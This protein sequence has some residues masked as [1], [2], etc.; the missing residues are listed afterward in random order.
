MF[1]EILYTRCRRGIDIL[2]NQPLTTDGF[3]VYACS[4]ALLEKGV[5]DLH[6]VQSVM[7]RKQSYADPSFMD[8]AYLYYVPDTGDPLLVNFHPVRFDAAGGGD[9]AKRPGNFLN[10]AMTGDFSGIYPYEMFGDSGV[11][12]AERQDES[13]FYETDPALFRLGLPDNYALEGAITDEDIRAFLADGREAAFRTALAFLIGQYALPPENRKYLLIQDD[14]SRKLELWIA[15]VESAF[16][17]KIAANVPFATRMADFLR[18]NRYTVNEAGAFQ[19]QINLQDARQKLRQYAMVVGV[20][21]KDKASANT[22]RPTQN[23]PYVLLDGVRKTAEFDADTSDPYYALVTRL[24]DAHR[25]FC[26]RFLQSFA[27]CR[28][29]PDILTLHRAFAAL[30]SDRSGARETA[31]SL[32]DLA[33]FPG[34]AAPLRWVYDKAKA[35][36][37]EI[38]ALGSAPYLSAVLWLKRMADQYHDDQFAARISD[39][40]CNVALAELFGDTPAAEAEKLWSAAMGEEYGE[41]AQNALLAGFRE[42]KAQL[43]A[44]PVGKQQVV[45]TAYLN[46]ALRRQDSLAYVRTA[47]ELA[48][49]LSGSRRE[50][51]LL[52]FLLRDDRPAGR[53]GRKVSDTLRAA[54]LDGAAAEKENAVFLLEFLFRADRGNLFA[55]TRTLDYL[56]GALVKRRMQEYLPKALAAYLEPSPSEERLRET[57]VWISGTKNL[58]AAAVRDGFLQIDQ[59]LDP[60]ASK[61]TALARELQNKK[62]KGMKCKNSAHIWALSLIKDKR[63]RAEERRSGLEDCVDQGF[64][65]LRD[66]EADREYAGNLAEVLASAELSPKELDV[67]LKRILKC[68]PYYLEEYLCALLPVRSGILHSSGHSREQWGMALDILAKQDE[69]SRP[70]VLSVLERVLEETKQTPKNLKALREDCLTGASRE[71]FVSVTDTLERKRAKTSFFPFLKPRK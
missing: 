58:D 21:T 2:R 67:L 68:P 13:Y 9:F 59:Y 14:E 32:A 29:G 52:E 45:F 66:R 22:V 25:G 42:R 36:L 37:D 23:S 44:L 19:A 54:L 64:P 57:L 5:C 16:S 20:C 48:V 56:C 55:D 28:P 27:L 18:S 8:D 34:D 33:R 35:R 17:P 69:R 30:N 40:A 15:A 70:I 6:F 24:D 46:A 31:A 41:K 53:E 49:E 10:D 62:P 51:A 50:T 47:A 60:A 39:T 65:G 43:G 12:R 63:L 1:H 61:Q 3:K 7:Q 26:G 38:A 11:W 4:P 71:L